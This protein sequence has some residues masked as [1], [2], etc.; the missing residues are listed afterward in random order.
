[1]GP[2]A[3][4]VDAE[5]RAGPSDPTRVT[6][7]ATS[8]W[9][10]AAIALD[11]MDAPL[12]WLDA[13]GLPRTDY[14]AIAMVIA[15]VLSVA[16]DIHALT[17]LDEAP[18]ESAIRTILGRIAPRGG[19]ALSA[20]VVVLL[21]LLPSKRLILSLGTEAAGSNPSKAIDAAIEYSLDRL[22][23]A[24]EEDRAIGTAMA[25]AAVDTAHIG[26]LLLQFEVGATNRPERKRRIDRLRRIADTTSRARFETALQEEFFDK[27][28]RLPREPEDDVVE[29]LE[30]SAR[31]LRQFEMHGRLLGSADRYEAMLE[32]CREPIHRATGKLRVED[33]VRL[34][35]ILIGAREAIA[36]LQ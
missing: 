13:T 19:P 36:L 2:E 17:Q 3:A 32:N 10:R 22:Q 11:S 1:L 33:Q 23:T 21:A 30:T 14:P 6:E 5:G 25:Q 27:L 35:E 20:V 9:P 4:E 15:A 31:G 29:N 8:I 34:T 16:V 24:L 18:P 7:L 28:D 26:E 12:G